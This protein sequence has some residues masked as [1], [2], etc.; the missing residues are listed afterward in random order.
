ML[1][2]PRRG[3]SLLSKFALASAAIMAALLSS[4]GI[5]VEAHCATLAFA[6]TAS[7]NSF[8]GFKMWRQV[9]ARPCNTHV[10]CSTASGHREHTA[11]RNP[12]GMQVKG[13]FTNSFNVQ[14]K[15]YCS[16]IKL[17]SH[18]QQRKFTRRATFLDKVEPQEKRYLNSGSYGLSR[19]KMFSSATAAQEGLDEKIIQLPVTAD[20]VVCNGEEMSSSKGSNG[21]PFNEL[22][23]SHETIDSVSV[24]KHSLGEKSNLSSIDSSR[25]PWANKNKVE[26]QD[27]LR[28]LGLKVTGTKKELIERLNEAT[29]TRSTDNGP[30]EEANF[31]SNSYLSSRDPWAK[32]NKVEI[33]DA[34]RK[35]GLKVTGTKKELLERLREALTENEITYSEQGDSISKT[36][37]TNSEATASELGTDKD[38]H[39]VGEADSEVKEALMEKNQKVCVF[40]D[41]TQIHGLFELCIENCSKVIIHF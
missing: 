30:R 14:S 9:K 28:K 27:A 24:P 26:I 22:R 17:S 33:Q 8:L 31:T 38:C 16:C 35:L 6:S 1:S 40:S 37:S 32:K 11:F 39:L 4:R 2:H 19:N 25:D 21:T 15:P 23:L 7:S 12:S 13:L 20:A 10:C 36:S 3:T 18:V 29:S 34:L 41:D 5:W